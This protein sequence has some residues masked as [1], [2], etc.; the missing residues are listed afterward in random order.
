MV[1][2]TT[3]FSGECGFCPK[4]CERCFNRIKES[5]TPEPLGRAE[6][7]S[8]F[9]G[10][11]RVDDIMMNYNTKLKEWCEEK[12]YRNTKDIGW[13]K[14]KI[15]VPRRNKNSLQFRLLQES[16]GAVCDDPWCKVG[17]VNSTEWIHMSTYTNL[18]IYECKNDGG[19]IIHFC[20]PCMSREPTG[21]EISS[22]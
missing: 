6:D 16:H 18:P 11:K 15:I 8:K 13:T 5:D 21:P 4:C 19:S 17:Y 20:G 3:C 22:L 7:L 10:K 14:T 9:L 12:E 1:F 2:A